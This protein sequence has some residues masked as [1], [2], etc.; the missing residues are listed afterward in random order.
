MLKQQNPHSG[1]IA[2]NRFPS[3]QNNV[4]YSRDG[5]RPASFD[6]KQSRQ[7]VGPIEIWGQYNNYR[8]AGL[9]GSAAVHAVLIALLVASASL[10]HKVV[11]QVK[12]PEHVTLIAP[13][14]DSYIMKPAKTEVSGGGGG[15]DRDQLQAP[16]GHLPKRAMQQI[17]PPQIIL[18]NE[19]P[20]LAVT[21]TVVIPPKVQV[22]ENHMPNLGVM[23]SPAMPSAPPSNGTGAGGGIGSGSGGGAGIGHGPGAGAGSG[24]GIGGGVY[25]VGGGIS[26]PRPIE[27]PDPAYTEE[28]RRAKI[29]G[30]CI[31][32]LIVDANGHPRDIRVIRGLGYGLD[33][34]ALET[35]KQWVFEPAR[36]DGQPV[37]VEVSVEVGFRLY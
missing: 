11:Q 23:A 27:T 31:L 32:G 9:K 10:G 28:A 35:V 1:T 19:K 18:R 8:A 12:Q 22:A 29:Q 20:K 3:S 17:T 33:A 15:G 2:L 7:S 16:K 34:K 4:S 14:L 5:R 25:K 21:P 6:V 13:P 37:N 24:G 26:A 36:K 30:T